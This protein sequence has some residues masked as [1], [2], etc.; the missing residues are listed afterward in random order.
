MKYT[1][2][3]GGGVFAVPD[4]AADCLKLASG[5]AVK[6]LLYILKNKITEMDFPAAAEDLGISAEDAEDAV[7]YWQQVGVLYQDGSQPPA[8][9]QRKATEKPAADTA[10]EQR[11][12]EKSAKM[13]SPEEIADRINN[14]SEIKF[15]FDSAE[16]AFGKILNYTEQ[17]TLI[18]LHDYYSIAPDLLLMIMD[19]AKQIGKA[20]ISYVE[21]IAINWQEN[22][23]TT[24]ELAAREITRLKNYCSFEGQVSAKLGLGRTLTPTEKKFL[25]EWADKGFSVELTVYAYE[26]TVDNI[27]KVKFSY[28]NKILTSW[29]ENGITT[30]AEAKSEAERRGTQQNGTPQDGGGEHSYNLDLLVAHAMNNTPQIKK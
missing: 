9:P 17:R 11:A 21:K 15:L 2:N 24:H 16:N 28:M 20:N 25:G 7:S 4:I 6:V 3:W 13:I 23:I 10:A 22:G 18:W 12:K 30:V 27:G 19:F 29:R 8:V 5:K 26:R 14:S 1:V